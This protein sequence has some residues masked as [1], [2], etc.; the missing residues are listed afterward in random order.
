VL[1]PDFSCHTERLVAYDLWEML[2]IGQGVFSELVTRMDQRTSAVQVAAGTS[3]LWIQTLTTT[4]IYVVAFAFMA[5]LISTTQMGLLAILSLILGLAQLIGP[6]ALPA[7]VARFVA[8]E[9]GQGRRQSA[10]AIFYQ[11]MKISMIVS[12]AMSIACFLLTPQLS[13]ALSAEPIIF[14]LLAIDIFVVAGLHQTI[15]N[16]LIG[17]QRFRQYSVATVAFTVIRQALIIS[18]LLLFRDFLWLVFAW[19]V[20]DL[21]YMLMMI[22]PL[23]RTLG[24]PT[25]EYSQ[26]QLLRFS[27]PLMPGNSVG[28]AYAWYDRALALPYVSLAQL[29]VYNATLTAFSVLSSIPG[30]IATALYP[31]YAQIQSSKGRRGLED[32]MRPASRY[33]SFIAIPLALGLFATARPALALFVGEPY[34]QGSTALQ[35]LAIFLALTVLGNA[36]ANI[37]LLLGKTWTASGATAISVGGSVVAAILLLP[38]LGINGAAVS[39]GVAMALSF[40]LTLLLVKN[41]IALAFDLEAFWKSFAASLVMALVVLLVQSVYYSRLLLPV[42]VVVGAC[43]YVAGLRLF[44]AVEPRDID[45]AKD[46]LGR[47]YAPLFH[48]FSK[49]LL[50]PSQ[51]AKAT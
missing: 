38:S 15:I 23:Y 44:R 12:A 41:Q 47:K 3:Y 21:L 20:S 4:L 45:L 34:D 27:L 17:A 35:I 2:F 10:A 46:F 32:A 6:L 31:A 36:F 26:K 24:P 11:S 19:V 48:V 49:L 1:V 7:A 42:Y 13:A 33:I 16:A 37:F 5:R 40:V 43:A 9:L 29:G 18:L 22:I 30:G 51:R 39:R 8:E 14:Q 50:T 28:F 25:F